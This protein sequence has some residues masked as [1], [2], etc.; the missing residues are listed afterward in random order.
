MRLCA[1]LLLM[2]CLSAVAAAEQPAF[3]GQ[4]RADDS[5]VQELANSFVNA[6]HDRTKCL[7]VDEIRAADAA[8]NTKPPPGW[9]GST[10]EYWT[11]VGCGTEFTALVGWY[12]H[13]N[14]F[15]VSFVSEF[16]TRQTP[17]N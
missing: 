6:V 8:P 2:S 17:P 4:T 14:G 11:A 7:K 9:D 3:S 1:L 15:H 10:V 16:T 12:V 13:P 5:L